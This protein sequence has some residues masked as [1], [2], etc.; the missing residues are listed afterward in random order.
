[1]EKTHI[2]KATLSDISQLVV[3]HVTAWQTAYAGHMPD[4]YLSALS[5]EKRT[6]DWESWIKEPG[7]GTTIVIETDDNIKGFCVFG[8]TRDDN[9][10]DCNTGEILALNVHPNFWR[11]G[12]GKI[13]CDSVLSKLNELNWD[14]LTLWALK[15]NKRA[16]L[17]YLS[18]G[19]KLDGA[20]RIEPLTDEATV[21]EVR[22]YINA[23]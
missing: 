9:I 4:N 20:N 23:K 13:L 11:C 7:P 6:R 17:F 18:L 21:E 14:T 2:R 10:S 5:V 3:I 19:F 15:S 16:Q 12:Y 22:Y 1:L 8:P